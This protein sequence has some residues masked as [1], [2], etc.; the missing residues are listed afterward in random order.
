[1]GKKISEMTVL[2]AGQEASGDLLTIVDVSDTTEALTG[3]NKSLSPD[4]F[5]KA[6]DLTSHEADVTNPHSVTKTQVGLSDVDNT[7]DVSKPVSTDQQTEIDTKEDD[8]GNP[9]GD[10][11]FLSSTIAG[12]RS[13]VSSSAGV[14]WGAITGTLSDQTDLQSALDLKSAITTVAITTGSSVSLTNLW[15]GTQASYDALTPDANT[16]YFITA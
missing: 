4:A 16:I 9:T 12:V 2:A 14:A 6:P 13:W 7:S 3:T 8:L 11:W 15:T 1:M 10:G 5:A